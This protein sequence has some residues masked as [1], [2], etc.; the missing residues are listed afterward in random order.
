MISS[1]EEIVAMIAFALKNRKAIDFQTTRGLSPV[2]LYKKTYSTS[3]RPGCEK[4]IHIWIYFFLY[5][6]CAPDAA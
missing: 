3:G 5:K 2:V 4:F 6:Y 1:R